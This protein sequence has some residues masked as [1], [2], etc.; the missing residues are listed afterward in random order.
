MFLLLTTKGFSFSAWDKI[1]SPKN[2]DYNLQTKF[3][4][5]PS[6]G[7]LS[8]PPWTASYWPT[9][10]GGISYRWL[11]GESKYKTLGKSERGINYLS[12]SEK[13]DIFLGRNDF[14]L[15]NYERKRTGIL[16]RKDIPTWEGICHDWAPAA[17][18]MKEPNPVSVTGKNG[19]EI[20]FGSSDIKALIMINF[21]LN[22]QGRRTKFLGSRCN[23]KKKD[24]GF[25][26][27]EKCDDTNAGAFHVVLT[28]LVGLRNESF[29]I[30]KTR[31]FEVWNQPVASYSS[32][33]IRSKR[34]ASLGAAK[35]TKKEV[36]VETKLNW[37]T[38]IDQQWE[39]AGTALE[40][41]VYKYKLVLDK[42]GRI[43]GGEWISWERPDFIWT[44]N[45][46][47]FSGFM[48]PLEKI[49]LKSINQ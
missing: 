6:N 48:A 29:V 25:S 26:R 7:K 49:Y 13:Y 21:E 4:K 35:G 24:Q 46:P 32:R 31:D 27:N 22:R 1:N 37:V 33:V 45:R 42:K 43:I 17:Y 10:Q 2:F 3:K 11:T 34:G 8:R 20:Y 36:I 14:P 19:E 47:N 28:N 23:L 9:Y 39:A 12:P 40:T 16:N 18:L 44:Q 15:T 30:D 38:E 5:L 41:S